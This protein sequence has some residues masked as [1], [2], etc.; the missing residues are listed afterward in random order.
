[1]LLVFADQPLVTSTHLQALM[2]SWSGS[3]LEIVATAY[4]G[5]QGPP[6]LFPRA[7]FDALC[8]LRG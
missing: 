8:D 7:T 1:M 6:V 3:E 5:T 2:D 4:K